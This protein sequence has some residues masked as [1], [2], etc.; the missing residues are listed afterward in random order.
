M[1]E[2][3]FSYDPEDGGIKFHDTSIEAKKRAEE[4]LELSKDFVS[5]GGWDMTGVNSICW[6]KVI[7]RVKFIKS[8]PAPKDS[9]FNIYDEYRLVST[10]DN[11]IDE[12]LRNFIRS[13]SSEELEILKSYL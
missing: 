7:E 2:K 9:E 10:N 11:K 12:K 8:K 13:L 1:T 5:D 4:G 6:G 3:Y